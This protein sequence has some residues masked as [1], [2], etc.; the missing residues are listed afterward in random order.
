MVIRGTTVSKC[1]WL[2]SEKVNTVLVAYIR[3]PSL[4][5][6]AH[7]AQLFFRK[8]SKA[9][10]KFNFLNRSPMIAVAIGF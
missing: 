9:L 2:L 1:Y 4:F 8:N 10:K 7:I 3:L 5:N 6:D